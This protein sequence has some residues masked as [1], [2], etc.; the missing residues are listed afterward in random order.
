MFATGFTMDL[1]F[2]ADRRGSARRF[3]S[4]LAQRYR[5]T[6]LAG[7]S[8][9]DAA[10]RGLNQA[11]TF[12]P[13]GTLLSTYTKLHPFSYG[14][15]AK[16][17]AKGADIAPYRLGTLRVCP[18]LCYDLRFPEIFRRATLGGTNLFAVLANWPA[19]REQHWV[20]LLQAR[21]IENQAWVAAVNR[22]GDDPKLHYAGRS[23]IIDPT[24]RI[25]AD[26]ADAQTV[27]SAPVSAAAVRRCRRDFPAL[28]DLRREFLAPSPPQTL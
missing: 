4:T 27:I 20:T 21:A 11:Q 5:S 25:V 28:A 26:A 2:H 8:T 16:F 9:L 14:A 10:G 12:A 23:F 6:I 1:A 3:L 17:F 7:T 15:E 24:G 22:V 13:D 18:I 19:A